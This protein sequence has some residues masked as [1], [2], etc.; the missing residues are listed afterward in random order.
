[1]C[2][3]LITQCL[4]FSDGAITALGANIF[5]MAV[6]P[7]LIIAPLVIAPFVEKAR[8]DKDYTREFAARV[9]AA[10]LISAVVGAVAVWVESLPTLTSAQSAVFFKDMFSA[11]LWVGVFEFAV[12]AVIIGVVA[13]QKRAPIAFAAFAVVG[14]ALSSLLASS[15]PDGLEY[16]LSQINVT[17]A[18][19]MSLF[20]E[21]GHLAVIGAAALL[22]LSIIPLFITKNRD[23]E[24]TDELAKTK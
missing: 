20:G 13:Q 24:V 22:A 2:A 5:N 19:T 8:N 14:S 23:N 7:C 21:Y 18:E 10:G 17:T 9:G 11:H 15:L 16:S 4:L 6:V 3:M 12:G 1:M